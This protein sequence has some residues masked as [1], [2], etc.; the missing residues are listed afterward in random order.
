MLLQVQNAIAMFATRRN[1]TALIFAGSNDIRDWLRHNADMKAKPKK[2]PG[3]EER[4][5]H[6]GSLAYVKL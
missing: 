6:G 4:Q 2:L 3:G 5:F 1:R